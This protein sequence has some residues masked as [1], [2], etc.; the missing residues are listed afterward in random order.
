[1][2]QRIFSVPWV[3]HPKSLSGARRRT[4]PLAT[5]RSDPHPAMRVPDLGCP[6][7]KATG[8]RAVVHK[9]GSQA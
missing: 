7:F 4:V 3:F 6:E 2:D 1:M 9:L 8:Q 5:L